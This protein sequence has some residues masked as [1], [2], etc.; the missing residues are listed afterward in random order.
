MGTTTVKADT[1]TVG[2][3]K[4]VAT[5]DVLATKQ[6]DTIPAASSSQSGSVSASTSL[7]VSASAS[8][9]VAVSASASASAVFSASASTSLAVSTSGSAADSA[10]ASSSAAS[11]SAS[12]VVNSGVQQIAARALAVTNTSTSAAGNTTT[13]TSASATGSASASTSAS[14]SASTSA[15]VSA[16]TSASTPSNL[17]AA[18]SYVASTSTQIASFNSGSAWATSDLASI[19]D[20]NR[21]LGILDFG[22]KLGYVS[23]ILAAYNES[24]AEGTPG[25]GSD[26]K[27]FWTGAGGVNSTLKNVSNTPGYYPIANVAHSLP[28]STASHY[29]FGGIFGVGAGWTSNVGSNINYDSTAVWQGYGQTIAQYASELQGWLNQVTTA[30]QQP[31]NQAAVM[32]HSTYRATDLSQTGNFFSSIDAAINALGSYYTSLTGGG[33]TSSVPTVFGY[34]SSTPL[35]NATAGSAMATDAS[36]TISGLGRLID[37]VMSMIQNSIVHQALSDVRSLGNGA[38]RTSYIPSTLTDAVA[39]NASLSSVASTIGLQPAESS[40]VATTVYNAIAN[41]IVDAV[42]RNFKYGMTN[43]LHSLF[44]DGFV[45]GAIV[46]DAAGDTPY[47]GDTQYKTLAGYSATDPTGVVGSNQAAGTVATMVQAAGYAWI[48]KVGK[49]LLTLAAADGAAGTMKANI[50]AVINALPAGTLTSDQIQTLLN[51]APNTTVS[52]ANGGYTRG[53]AGDLAAQN[54]LMQLYTSEYNAVANAKADYQNDPGTKNTLTANVSKNTFTNP[55]DPN[56]T[57]PTP[58]A[59]TVYTMQDYSDVYNYLLTYD[60]TFKGMV[61]ADTASDN[62]ARGLSTEKPGSISTVVASPGTLSA[63]APALTGTLASSNPQS[64]LQAEA[65]ADKAYV[66]A[67]AAE[68]T[69]ANAAYNAGV[70]AAKAG[71]DSTTGIMKTTVD[72]A[73]YVSGTTTYTSKSDTTAVA[74]QTLNNNAGLQTVAAGTAFTEGY[75]SQIATLTVT[76]SGSGSTA[77]PAQ[78]PQVVEILKGHEVNITPPAI[79]GWYAVSPTTI[80]GTYTTNATVNVVYETTTVSAATSAAASAS[81]SASVASTAQS[82]SNSASAISASDSASAVSAAQSASDSASAVSATQSASDSASAASAA[83]S[84]SDSASAVSATQSASDSASAVSAAQ[85]ASDSASAVSATQSASDSASAVSATQS[86]SDSAS[87]VSATQSAS[88]SASAVSAA[89]SASDSA[90]AVSATQSASDSASAV[91]ATQSASDSASAV[92]AT[93]SAS[94]SASAVSATQSAS[95]SASAVSAAQ[96]ASD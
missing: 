47:V 7:S 84:A 3:S 6:T 50:T 9:S 10:S 19:I 70:A 86:A 74:Y 79:D 42:V 4:Q 67:Y 66:E 40:A 87:A 58:T 96:S 95:D 27:P 11:A 65:L 25:F 36:T 49:P 85:S 1:T 82:A 34:N 63:G 30:M 15:T 2:A 77:F 12:N 13:S 37:L 16:S 48:M 22:T 46:A 64:A 68:A 18:A 51:N 60:A 24:I 54:F 28:P 8:V 94:D 5:Q 31:A 45:N 20:G 41:G 55:G 93:Q 78:V 14:A 23:D 59:A 43:A 69:R 52:G 21:V 89:Q 39:L 80:T 91:S 35:G 53:T 71:V 73:S 17:M 29:W 38:D 61:A 26:G 83:Q 62:A 44:V 88:D 92:S 76:A 57:N 33:L 72:T 90:S 75:N 32:N 81:E 56:L